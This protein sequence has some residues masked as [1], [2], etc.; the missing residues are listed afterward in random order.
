[1][2][3]RM[4]AREQ[5]GVGFLTRLGLL[6]SAFILFLVFMLWLWQTSW[7]QNENHRI[8]ETALSLT[9]KAQFAV[10]DII[11]EGRHQ[12][13]KDDVYDALGTEQNA[14]IFQFDSAAAAQRLSKLPWVGSAV[15]ERRLPDTVA[16]I[17]TERIPAA[18]WQRDDHIYVIDTQGHVLPSARAEDFPGL[19][20]V[21]GVGA[22]REAQGFLMLLKNY[23]EIRDKTESA[24]RV[25]E[26]RWDLHLSPKIIVRLPE[27]DV[28]DALHRLSVL[29][30]Q[31]KILERSIVAI[32]LRMPDRLIVEPAASDKPAG[33]KR[34]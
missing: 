18:R 21:V 10:K 9:Q 29:I 5:S 12:S 27:Q 33:D 15:V 6:A 30:T 3:V 17:L 2:S 8:E 28:G 34:L 19:S 26:R 32:D 16:V 23:P 22:E 1:M 25:G 7:L 24:V 31:D 4:R 20:L 13:S 11:V 14:P